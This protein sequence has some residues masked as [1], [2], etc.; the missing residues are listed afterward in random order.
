MIKMKYNGK[1]ECYNIMVKNNDKNNNNVYNAKRLCSVL[2]QLLSARTEIINECNYS[3]HTSARTRA[4]V[5]KYVNVDI[6]LSCHIEREE[7]ER[8]VGREEGKQGGSEGGQDVSE[9]ERNN[10]NK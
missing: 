6:D 10:H 2:L 1:R 9:V 5:V 7:G 4:W 3:N 8:G